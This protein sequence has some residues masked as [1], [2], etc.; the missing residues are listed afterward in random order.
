MPRNVNTLESVGDVATDPL[1]LIE[2]GLE[3]GYHEFSMNPP[4]TASIAKFFLLTVPRPAAP[5]NQSGKPGIT[6]DVKGV[7]MDFR[8]IGSTERSDTT[9]AKDAWHK[10]LSSVVV[11]PPHC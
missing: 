6:M 9:D 4:A 2:P 5:P 7:V 10:S 3:P 8:F 11:P 1:Y